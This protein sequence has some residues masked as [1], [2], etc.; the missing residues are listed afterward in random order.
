M[1]ITSR[2][3]LGFGQDTEASAGSTMCSMPALV[4][5]EEYAWGENRAEMGVDIYRQ[6]VEVT[7]RYERSCAN[8]NQQRCRIARE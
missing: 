4:Q 3:V 7:M 6:L 8:N 2:P 5:T 1:R